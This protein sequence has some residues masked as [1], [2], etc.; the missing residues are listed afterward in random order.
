MVGRHR[1]PRQI[2]CR[3]VALALSVG[4]CLR[5]RR[6]RRWRTY[7]PVTILHSSAGERSRAGRRQLGQPGGPG[8]PRAPPPA[9]SGCAI[10]IGASP[11][12][13]SSGPGAA[14]R[15]HQPQGG[16]DRPCW[17]GW[18]PLS[19]GNEQGV[20][21]GT[22]S[23]VRRAPHHITRPKN[24][25]WGKWVRSERASAEQVVNALMPPGRCSPTASNASRL[26]RVRPLWKS[27][28]PTWQRR[29]GS[30][31]APTGGRLEQGTWDL[32]LL[33][34]LAIGSVPRL[35]AVFSGLT[36]E[37]TKDHANGGLLDWFL[38]GGVSKLTSIR[39]QEIPSGNRVAS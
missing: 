26:L 37:I 9:P 16:P 21:G 18:A 14:G 8:P 13:R 3:G 38:Y 33:R 31:A 27:N 6:G 23:R 15:H 25:T 10:R 17:P 35:S 24:G 22:C 4:A 20:Q 5:G 28:P 32:R 11:S 34:F 12:R 1:T 30:S 19:Q 7:Q 29:P 36:E 39:P 2:C